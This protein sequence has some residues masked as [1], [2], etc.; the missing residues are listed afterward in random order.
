MEKAPPRR[1]ACSEGL[2]GP[3][4]GRATVIAQADSSLF[5]SVVILVLALRVEA[6]VL[7]RAVSAFRRT[8]KLSRVIRIGHPNI[9]TA[10]AFAEDRHLRVFLLFGM[11]HNSEIL[12]LAGSVRSGRYRR[13]LLARANPRLRF[14]MLKRA[15]R[16]SF[17]S[18]SVAGLGS[19][20][21]SGRRQTLI[22]N[23][24]MMRVLRAIEFHMTSSSIGTEIVSGMSFRHIAALDVRR[25]C[26]FSDAFLI[27]GVSRTLRLLTEPAIGITF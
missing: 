9:G 17:V 11:A 1:D 21:A 2:N 22:R 8:W 16:S 25:G 6:A 19:G 5:F 3:C 4:Q 7:I 26:F 20:T 10:A 14:G 24:T 18:R 12:R 23:V 13:I 15:L 27:V